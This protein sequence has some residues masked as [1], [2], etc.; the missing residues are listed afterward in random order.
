MDAP[1]SFFFGLEK[2]NGQ[3][4]VIHSL[5]SGTGQEITE[6][7]QIRRRAV[8]FYS[9]LYASEYEEGETLSEGLWNGLPQVSEEANSQLEGPLTIQELQTALQGMQGRRAPGI[10]GLSMEFYKAYWD[11]LSND[12]LDV[13]N[14]S[15]ASGSMPVSCRRAVI[16][17]LPK[18]GNLQDIKN[19][20]PVS[21][22]CVDYKLLS[23]ALAT[24]LGR[25]VEQVIHRDQTYCVPGR[26][27]VDNVH[28]IRDVLEVSSSLDIN[29]G[30]ISL[31]QE[32]AFDRVEHSFLWKV[33]GKFGFSAGFIAKIKV[34]YNN[35][36]SVLKF[37]GGL[38]APFRV[39]RG[40]RQGC[41]LSGMLY[42]LSLEPL[43]SKIRSKLQGLF[44]PGFNGNLVLS[45]YA[46]DVVVFVRDQ[47]DMDVLVDIVREFSSASAA[48]VN[49]KKSGGLPVLPQN[50]V[51]RK[52]GF[53]L[54]VSN[55]ETPGLTVAL[56]RSK[57]LC[58]Q[59]L[60][61]AVGPELSDAQ[62]LGSLLGLHSVRVAQRILQLW[63][64]IL[65]PE[66]KRLLRSY[67]QGGA[68]PDP[69]DPFPEIYLSPGLG[70]LTGPLLQVEKVNC[71]IETGITNGQRRVIHSLLSGTGQEI[72]E[73]SQ[74]RRRAV[75]CYST[76][77]TSEYEE[78]ETLSE[79]FCNGLPQVSEEANSQLEGPLTIQEL[80][81]ALQGMQG[82]RAPGIDGL[83]VEFYK[84]YWDVLS[85][86]LLDVFNESLASGSMPVS[87]RRAV[88]T[89]LPKKGN[90]QDIKNWRPVSLL[91]VDYKILSKALATRLG[92]AVEQVIHRDQTYCV[93]GRSMVDNVHLIR[94][95]LEVSSSLG[96][97]TAKIKVLYNKIESVLKFNGVCAPFR[98]CRGVRQGCALSG[99]LYALSLEPLL[100]KIRSKLQGLFLPGLNGNM[101]LSVYADDVVVFVRDQKD[102]DILVDIVRDFS[103]ASAARVNWKK[104]EAL[105]VGEWSGGLP[106]LP[107][108]MVWKKDGFKY[109]GVFLGKEIVVLKNWEDVI[110]KIEGKLSK[111]KWLLPQMSFK[112]RLDVSSSE[113]PGLTVALCRSKTLCLQQ[114]VDAVGP[115]LSD[116]QALGSLLGLHS[117]RVAQ[118]ILQ[119]WSQILCPEE[120]RLLRSY[121]Q[122]R[123]RPDPADPFPEIYLSPGL[124]ELTGP[125]LQ[126]PSEFFQWA[127]VFPAG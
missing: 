48:R 68:R 13:F 123:A 95:V 121:G 72:T 36:E 60:V 31:D 51:W 19:W 62:A 58:L 107:Q 8:S 21:L 33:M 82:R 99:M 3:R 111:W 50:M 124:G 94:D 35:I 67:G 66:E 87:C 77:Y 86:D 59:Q 85:H 14:E 79:G 120:K 24:R 127:K 70:E 30:L 93:P 38:C 7:S 109:L 73:P 23:K 20:R 16:T 15:L 10:D 25:A 22:L 118:R 65:C 28:L 113:T 98:V 39:C 56:C 101:V 4:R 117:V 44:L 42:A 43:L 92:K 46:D 32:K 11:V 74:I 84:A 83:Y 6:P 97:N 49:W 100:S 102:T 71:V 9:T 110:E 75:S 63:S 105:A 114:L 78:G 125:L 41:A 96:I 119:L 12:L 115:E 91:C 122:G 2:K 103:S 29:T 18:K 55:S 53:K 45:A 52:D 108:N 126:A 104:S 90:L 106:V 5:L 61:D 1:T 81:T 34:L 54:D 40:V 57:T 88:I 47:T 17:L 76:L 112:A 27:M 37:N 69:A 116:A 64:Q 26:S 80:Q 89:L